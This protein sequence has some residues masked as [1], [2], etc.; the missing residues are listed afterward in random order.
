NQTVYIRFYLRSDAFVTGDGYYVD[1]LLIE[2]YPDGP[3][4]IGEVKKD[5][6]KIFPNPAS[7]HFQVMVPPDCRGKWLQVLNQM[8]EEIM[9][10]R[11]T[12]GL[13]SINLQEVPAGIYLLRGELQ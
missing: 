5:R 12:T 3:V 2:T 7:D 8:G 11:L 10:V 1:D 6:W 13:N 9:R 4:A